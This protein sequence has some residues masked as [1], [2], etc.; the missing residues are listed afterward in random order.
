MDGRHWGAETVRVLQAVVFPGSAKQVSPAIL[1]Q[2]AVSPSQ[3]GCKPEAVAVEAGQ[4]KLLAREGECRT[5]SGV[6]QKEA[7]L[8]EEGARRKAK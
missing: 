5:G 1:L 4:S 7:E 6:A 3:Q 8:L 2:G